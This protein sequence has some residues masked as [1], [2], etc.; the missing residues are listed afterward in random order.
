[1]IV[2]MKDFLLVFVTPILSLRKCKQ[3]F[4]YLCDNLFGRAWSRSTLTLVLRIINSPTTYYHLQKIMTGFES[5]ILSAKGTYAIIML[6]FLLL[7]PLPPPAP[8][9]TAVR[10][11]CI[12]YIHIIYTPSPRQQVFYTWSVNNFKTKNLI[13]CLLLSP[14]PQLRSH[15]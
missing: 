4:W 15:S 2:Y 11:W 1:M 7:L 8:P 6:C 3:F 9:A 5:Q 12:R 14:L 10:W 13:C